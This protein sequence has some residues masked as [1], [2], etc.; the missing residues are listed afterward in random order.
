MVGITAQIAGTLLVVVILVDIFLAVLY[1]RSGKGW[2]GVRLGRGIW[3]IFRLSVRTPLLKQLGF[4]ASFTQTLLS[5]TGPT[6]LVAIVS[7]WVLLLLVGFALIFWAGLGTAIRASEGNTP[8]DFAT[9]FYLSGYNLTTLGVGDILP[10]NTTYRLLTILE[11]A[12]G[13]SIFTLTITY[14]LAI[15]SALSQRNI[16][17]LSL[18]Y[19][20]DGTG[21]AV[22]MLVRCGIGG[23][24]AEIR[25]EIS[26][27]S[28]NLLTLLESHHAY[29][30]VHYFRFRESHYALSRIVLIAMD[31]AALLKT[32]LN[33]AQYRW[34]IN[35]AAVAELSG[36]GLH[37]LSELAS[38][39]LPEQRP[40]RSQPSER[41]LRARYYQAVH[42]LQQ[43]GVETRSDLEAGADQY[44]SL[45]LQWEPYIRAIADYMGY[46]WLEIAPYEREFKQGLSYRR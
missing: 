3:R 34:L 28:I 29:P 37:L 23:S 46:D 43:E 19:R 6:I 24:F 5:Y 32:T 22:E 45:R 16:F 8:T 27:I 30:V 4:P 17:A 15:Y 20:T 38:T 31:T 36:G 41:L 14:L 21:D 40:Y 7:V 39:F 25:E 35:S 33:E 26:N 11:A 2:L 1:P 44:V 9:A 18:H 13:F 12:L 42:R 10:Q